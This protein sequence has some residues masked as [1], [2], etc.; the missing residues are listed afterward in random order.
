MN[1]A[2]LH[3]AIEKWGKEAQIN[4]L[5]EEALELAL[6]LNQRKCPTKDAERMEANLYDELADMLI[7]LAQAEII[8]DAT[9]INDRV[10]FKLEKLQ[11]KL[12]EY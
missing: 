9:R 5:Q 2:I 4:K 8:F 3:K 12:Y 7:M 11:S 1:K 6:A 10:N